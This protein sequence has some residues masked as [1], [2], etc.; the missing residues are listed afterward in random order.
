M[1]SLAAAGADNYYYP[2]GW[3]PEKGSIN[4]FQKSHPLGKR[5]KYIHEGILIVRFEMPF[6]VWC[7]S[8]NTH[9]G[10]GVRFNAKKSKAGMYLT[11][12]I[13]EFLLTCA[14]CKSDMVVRTDPKNQTYE[15]V[16]GIRQK[17]EAFTHE[18]NEAERLNDAD[19]TIQLNKDPIFRLEHQESDRLVASAKASTLERLIDL[20]D[21][22][23]D[24]YTIN[25]TLRKSFRT[26]KHTR[27]KQRREAASVG[28]VVPMAEATAEDHAAVA[29]VIFNQKNGPK[30]NTI[31]ER[32]HGASQKRN[33]ELKRSSIFEHPS[34]PKR[35]NLKRKVALKER[36]VG[37]DFRSF[38]RP[39]E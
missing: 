14:T 15:M 6:N 7:T 4:T 13:Y 17:V 37:I 35:S 38:Q 29:K 10:K 12:Q 36:K 22:R 39:A 1:S 3:A 5:A 32:F 11:T 28:I 27:R 16:S 26:Q 19:T 34:A 18:Q 23:S 25:A 24:Q 31:K 21:S 8:C 30:A 2:A 9:I 33:L 20:Q